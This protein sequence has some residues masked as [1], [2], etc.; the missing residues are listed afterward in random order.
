MWQGQQQEPQP[1]RTTDNQQSQTNNNQQ[2]QTTWKMKQTSTPVSTA[3]LKV[4]NTMR[5]R[6]SRVKTKTMGRPVQCTEQRCKTH[7]DH[8]DLV[9]AAGNG[10]QCSEQPS[11]R[12]AMRLRRLHATGKNLWAAHPV[13]GAP[14]IQ[15]AKRKEAAQTMVA[16]RW[17][18]L[19]LKKTGGATMAPK[20]CCF[21]NESSEAQR[22]MVQPQTKEDKKARPE[23]APQRNRDEIGSPSWST[24]AATVP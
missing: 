1:Q 15:D 10:R 9:T 23:P 2:P 19:N 18:A 24:T 8:R 14:W 11:R 13:R 4:Q 17:M 20:N 22:E 3:T 12:M 5:P 6:G 21:A 16:L 7:R